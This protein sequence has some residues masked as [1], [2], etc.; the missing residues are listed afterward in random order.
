MYCFSEVAV[1]PCWICAFHFTMV[2]FYIFTAD[3]EARSDSVSTVDQ[4]KC[5]CKYNVHVI[6]AAQKKGEKKINKSNTLEFICTFCH[7]NNT[8][9]HADLCLFCSF[10]GVLC[11]R[12]TVVF[13]YP[14]L[15]VVPAIFY[16]HVNRWNELIKSGPTHH[17]KTKAIFWFGR[18][19]RQSMKTNQ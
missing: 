18:T 16:L 10:T 19:K 12:A 1:L 8:F 7:T 3:L 6:L 2:L 17:T 14:D 5:N 15:N 4:N 13:M 11:G 9:K